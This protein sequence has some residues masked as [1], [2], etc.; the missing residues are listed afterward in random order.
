MG[1]RKVMGPHER[2]V[3]C[4][5]SRE[6]LGLVGLASRLASPLSYLAMNRWLQA[7]AYRT[8]VGIREFL[9]AGGVAFLIAALT[10]SYHA[11]RLARG[12]PV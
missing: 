6:F 2:R 12:N 9:L 1:V 11:I 3:I 4:L 5:L 8:S 7:F 10:T